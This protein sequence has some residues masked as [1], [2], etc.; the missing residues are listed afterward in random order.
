MIPYLCVPQLWLDCIPV[1]AE[2]I[3]TAA[4][5]VVAL[6]VAHRRARRLGIDGQLLNSFIVWLVVGAL[7]GG[8]V[9]DLLCYRPDEIADFSQGA[10]Y[11]HKPW[12]LLFVWDGWRSV[13]GFFGAFLGVIIWRTHILQVTDWLRFSR[14]TKVEGYWFVRR[15]RAEPIL[16]LA[17]V[18][19]SVFPVAWL[20]NRAGS[21]LIHDH[22]GRRA[23]GGSLFAVAF[24]D[25][26]VSISTG[27]S[28]VQGS[29]PRYDLGLLE[30]GVTLALVV[31]VVPLW[32]RPLRAGTYVCLAGLT[33]P[34]ARFA[35]D[36]LRR[37]T[38]P[39]LDPVYGS[40]TPAQWGFALLTALS[41]LLLLWIWARP[42]ERS[43]MA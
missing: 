39:A 34:P 33:Y 43:H 5:L 16:P 42:F 12:E 14:H 19:L 18:A 7:I 17:D 8:H 1:D 22:P 9:V 32:G 24:P 25:S 2:S 21:A 11:W 40:L 26:T 31:V 38:G 4:G 27:F 36:F 20:L 35:L 13:G 29:V 28:V 30:L 37:R 41:A 3:L 6:V 10:V 15:E 23:A